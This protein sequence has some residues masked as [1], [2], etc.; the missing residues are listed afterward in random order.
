[1]FINQQGLFQQN[2]FYFMEILAILLP[3]GRIINGTI[4]YPQI[5]PLFYYLFIQQRR[6]A[7]YL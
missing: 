7:S 3:H 4:F 5:V 2:L 6:R 1:M